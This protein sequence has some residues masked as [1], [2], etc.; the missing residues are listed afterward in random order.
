MTFFRKHWKLIALSG[1]AV[2]V[3]YLVYKYVSGQSSSASSI[4]AQEA[5]AQA[6]ADQQAQLDQALSSLGSEGGTSSGLNPIV[7]PGSINTGCFDQNGNPIPC[8]P[9]SGSGG[10]AVSTSGSVPSQQT[11][12]PSGAPAT[13]A[14]FSTQQAQPTAA[15]VGAV[16]A[17]STEIPG[18]TSPSVPL[19][20]DPSTGIS[21]FG[22]QTYQEAGNQNVYAMEA[23]QGLIP[24]FTQDQFSADYNAFLAQGNFHPDVFNSLLGI[25][26][27][28][29][30]TPQQLIQMVT[31]ESIDEGLIPGPGG[32]TTPIQATGGASAPGP[33]TP[34]SQPP[35]G[36]SPVN[37]PSVSGVG[38]GSAATA[39]G[40]G[41][42]S[43][44]GRIPTPI[45]NPPNAVAPAPV[46]P[47]INAPIEGPF[48]VSGFPPV[49]TSSPIG[50]GNK[51][52]P[53][54]IRQPILFTVQ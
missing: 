39:V 14:V 42:S 9:A 19:P 33:I 21:C 31:Q 50:R 41:P 46:T 17:A 5:A 6:Q 48:P 3:L 16:V 30:A 37:A 18:S 8:A 13:P 40:Q 2:L 44:S 25:S 12:N 7:S 52:L 10:T 20:C 22:S 38:R 54:P 26:P 35:G 36:G 51:N 27:T 23:N 15:Q 28:G 45:S 11:Q 29:V 47:P 24:N 49:R 34:P 32:S 53:K 1:G 43:R 4:T